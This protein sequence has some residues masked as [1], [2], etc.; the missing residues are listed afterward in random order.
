LLTIYLTKRIDASFALKISC[1]DSDIF[2][3]SINSLKFVIP[4]AARSYDRLSKCWIILAQATVEL[5]SYLATMVARF[6]ADVVAC[7]EESSSK[8]HYQER[9]QQGEHAS[10]EQQSE[11]VFDRR[12]KMTLQRACAT[13]YVTADAPSEVVQ[14]AYRALA[15]LH[16]PDLGGDGTTMRLI[17]HAYE[18]LTAELKRQ[19]AASVA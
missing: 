13:L 3:S 6:C 12:R 7:A 19:A 9:R 10:E 2:Q 18:V 17:N 4:V 16:H 15:K 8:E 11:S 1:P 5:E 14:G